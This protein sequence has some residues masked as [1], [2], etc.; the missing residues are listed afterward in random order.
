MP[1]GSGSRSAR[2]DP[3][4]RLRADRLVSVFENGSIEIHYDYVEDLRDGRGYTVGRG[5]CT[6]TGDALRV[7][8]SYVELAPNDPI[9]RFIPELQRLAD[10]GSDDISKLHGFPE[11][12]RA[13]VKNAAFRAAEDAEVDRSSYTPATLHA[14]TLGI[15]TALGLTILYDAVV[16]HGDGD[17]EDG[18]PA[19]VAR[20]TA[21]AGGSPRT[22]IEERVWLLRFLD[23][24]RADLAHAHDPATRKAWAEAVGRADV[25]KALVM[26]GN[27]D[28]RGPIH[29]GADYDVDV[30]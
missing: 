13:A 3:E 8:K 17:D 30:P 18:V 16:M 24:R 21:A 9:A 2:L 12:W 1:P 25:L 5:F 10:Q 23:V 6:G 15:H 14:D 29:V 19:L 11:A 7:I 27:D 28:L 22:G 4:Q 26:S 20:T